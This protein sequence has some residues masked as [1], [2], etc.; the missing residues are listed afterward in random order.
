MSAPPATHPDFDILAAFGLGRLAPAQRQAVEEHVR[1]C[2]GCAAALGGVADDTLLTMARA[3]A[4]T[5]PTL[6]DVQPPARASDGAPAELVGHPRY[7]VL[8]HVGAGALGEVFRV[9]CRLMRR[10]VALKVI[11]REL[12]AKPGA[13]ARFRRD[14]RAAAQLSHPNIVNAHDAEEAG[15]LHFLVME[16]VD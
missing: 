9:E 13:V 16:Y 1:G 10:V 11:R 12:L 6:Q 3:A 14:V 7:H 4:A 8:E 15:G 2:A 5:P